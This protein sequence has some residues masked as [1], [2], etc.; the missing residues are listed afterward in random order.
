MSLTMSLYSPALPFDS[1]RPVD[2]SSWGNQAW[3]D[4]LECD[5]YQGTGHFP[6]RGS[7]FRNALF[8]QL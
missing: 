3:V 6:A 2:L 7:L 4:L 8:R 5:A 1:M